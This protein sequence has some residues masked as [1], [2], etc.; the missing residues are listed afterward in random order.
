MPSVTQA[1]PAGGYAPSRRGRL[2]SFVLALA[3]TFAFLAVLVSMGRMT[4]PDAGGGSRL[5]AIALSGPKATQDR[6]KAQKAPQAKAVTATNAMAPPKIPP[7]VDVPAATHFE[8][9]PGFIHMSRSE[10]ASA[11]IGA[12]HHAAP[13]GAGA[14][15]GAGD[16]KGQGQGPGGGTL[17][18]AE[19]YR[20][21]THAELSGYIQPG[22]APAEWA[23]I[24]CRT[25]EKFHV[26]DC[27]ELDE[28]PRG[29]G[30]ARALRQAAW[31]FLVR[32]PRV[33]GK[34]MIGAWVRIRFD[35][36]KGKRDSDAG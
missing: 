29:S 11:D 4:M 16:S 33:D 30:M 6:A 26:D 25:I 9:P 35:F 5:V 36:T 15:E 34:P 8:L 24:A 20:E 17:Y 32:P 28:S 21:P 23:M 2:T 13:P 3:T 31:Q 27:R 12:M 7:H 14:G 18:N 19:W 22:Q 1:G 10:L